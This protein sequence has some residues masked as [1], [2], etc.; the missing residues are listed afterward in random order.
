MTLVTKKMLNEKE[1]ARYIGMSTGFLALARC[2]GNYGNRT[3]GPPFY[4]IG[5]RVR[6][7]ID[8]LDNWLE[9]HRCEG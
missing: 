4:K 7:H 5:R 1:A 3:P 9:R 2:Q 8:D 6:Y